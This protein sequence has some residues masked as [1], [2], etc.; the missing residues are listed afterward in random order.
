MEAAEGAVHVDDA[1]LRQMA[2]EAAAQTIATCW[3]RHRARQ[4]FER[5]KKAL[6]E[7]EG[8][9]ADE[10]LRQLCPLEAQLL[11]DSTLHPRVR[12]RLAGEDFPPR[13]VFKVFV[14]KK[15]SS[16]IYMSGKRMIKPAS[17]AAEDAM[18]V[19]GRQRF[20]ELMEADELQ[21]RVSGI[22]DEID[23]TS[24]RDFMQLTAVTDNMAASLGGRDNGWRPLQPEERHGVLFDFFTYCHGGELTARL[25]K[26]VPDLADE[27]NAVPSRTPEEE[28]LLKARA[29]EVPEWC[30]SSHCSHD[31][32][33]SYTCCL[34]RRVEPNV[35][36]HCTH[37]LTL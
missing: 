32:A 11:A 5:L 31:C 26:H 23:V 30:P 29:A 36:L 8:S 1:E 21:H 6:G 35:C 12:F 14:S 10:V 18:R 33:S 22:T 4:Q 16:V 34:G 17:E 9:V 13:V 19:M 20:L 28:A 3:R 24:L 15:V 2:E 37:A 7:A 27:D 25:Q